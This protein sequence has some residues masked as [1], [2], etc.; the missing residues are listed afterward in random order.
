LITSILMM[1]FINGL[2]SNWQNIDGESFLLLSQSDIIKLMKIRLGPAIKI[3][4]CLLTIR[5]VPD[6]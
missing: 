3:Y 4:N 5:N 6:I 1:K 2:Y